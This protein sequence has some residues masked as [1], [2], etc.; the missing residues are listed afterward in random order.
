MLAR[1][2][3]TSHQLHH[4]E[5]PALRLTTAIEFGRIL[6]KLRELGVS[7][8]DMIAALRGARADCQ[9]CLASASEPARSP[10]SG[11]PYYRVL[12]PLFDEYT[13]S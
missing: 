7:P 9:Q 6:K 4:L 11:P 12:G 1:F 13:R 3:E 2:G 8:N 5:I 10:A